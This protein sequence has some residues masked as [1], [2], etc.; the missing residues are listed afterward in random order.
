MREKQSHN[1]GN[2]LVQHVQRVTHMSVMFGQQR[3]YT[4]QPAAM[5]TAPE[6]P[7]AHP[8][9][10]GNVTTHQPQPTMQQMPTQ[11]PSMPSS[12]R[13]LQRQTAVSPHEQATGNNQQATGNIGNSALTPQSPIQRT[14][15]QPTTNAPRPMNYP[16]L[17]ASPAA[18]TAP[19][20]A[21]VQ[22]QTAVS[23]HEQSTANN[24]Q[25]TINSE[26][27]A[28]TPQH[29][30]HNPQSPI[31]RTPQPTTNAPRPMNYPQH[32]AAA[33]AETAPQQAPVQR[34]TAVSPHEQSTANN[35]QSTI[36]S[37]NSAL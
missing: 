28:L 6:Q 25:S 33:A 8:S 11:Q 13:G 27:S 1:A 31:Q 5:R 18:E 16:H 21:P 35:Q 20:Q 24:Q 34:Q 29:S 17:H 9:S 22:R 26:N 19:Q 2:R 12:I 15:E 37:E 30:A 3:P 32:H 7:E 10:T 4:S 23:P 36:N 14:P